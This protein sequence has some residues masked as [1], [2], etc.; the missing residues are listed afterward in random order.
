[1]KSKAAK[2]VT[3]MAVAGLCLAMF[4]A[5]AGFAIWF[6]QNFA[7]VPKAQ[8]MD[9]L[10]KSL[11]D[12]ESFKG[13]VREDG[14]ISQEQ[15][16]ALLSE[17]TVNDLLSGEKD[18]N[19]VM[20]EVLKD[21]SATAEAPVAPSQDWAMNPRQRAENTQG[22]FRF[23]FTPGETLKYRLSASIAGRGMEAIGTSPIDMNLDSA[24]ALTTQS[25]DNQGYGK[26]RM[27][28]GDTQ[29]RGDFMGSPFLMT[30]GS[31]GTKLEMNGMTYIDSAA[32]KGS[33]AGIPQL[34]F[35][36][37]PID[38]E[39]AP[40]GVVT[41]ISGESGMG[42][43]MG[44]APMFTDIEFPEGEL[45]AGT[46]WI[47]QVT[48]PVPGFGTP[49]PTTIKNTFTGYKTI[50]NRLCAIIDQE[51]SGKQ[52]QGKINAPASVLGA[53][54]GF[55]MPEFSLDGNNK[56]Y[57][58]VENGQMV[59]SDLDLDLGIDI[60]KTL[61]GSGDQLGGLLENLGDILGDVPEFEAYGDLL[62]KSDRRQGPANRDMKNTENLLEMNV[63]IKAQMSLTDPPAP[64]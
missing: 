33:S 21:V 5:G 39:V 47:S 23:K 54:L 41:A 49:I 9:T 1:M 15:I 11:Q 38:M 40:N 55:S 60:G 25:V 51:I 29:A 37:K 31:Q 62:P 10:A 12:S 57:F 44:A 17:K 53:A 45:T 52:T 59:H 56:V 27:E 19:E 36:D 14:T 46:T 24:F 30:R 13:L 64:Q 6:N 2:A 8:M 35:F 48:M 7:I 32:N 28:F 3:V 61:G 16:D 22:A 20:E 42:A 50:G 4:V 18:V 63:D 26:L 34:E 58:D 43:I